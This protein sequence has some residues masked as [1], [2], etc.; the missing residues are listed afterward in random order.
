[1]LSLYQNSEWI[2]TP[3][4]PF[5]SSYHHQYINLGSTLLESHGDEVAIMQGARARSDMS[6]VFFLFDEFLSDIR[7]GTSLFHVH[8]DHHVQPVGRSHER[9]NKLTTFDFFVGF[10]VYNWGLCSLTVRDK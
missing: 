6:G 2:S 10:P 9:H 8:V 4:S 3:G 7:D 5:S 1:M